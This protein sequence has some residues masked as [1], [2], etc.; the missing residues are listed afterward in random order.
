[1]TTWADNNESYYLREITE[2]ESSVEKEAIADFVYQAGTSS[3]VFAIGSN[4]Y[5]R[6][7]PGVRA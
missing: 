2:K 7:R 4:L 3:A 5:V 6:L 1:M